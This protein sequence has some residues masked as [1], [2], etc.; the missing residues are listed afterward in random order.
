MFDLNIFDEPDVE[1]FHDVAPRPRH[2]KPNQISSR[3]KVQPAWKEDATDTLG[4]RQQLDQS[5]ART[6]QEGGSTKDLQ[7]FEIFLN[8]QRIFTN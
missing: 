5:A 1:S 2:T 4:N 6:T 3:P 7:A 8:S